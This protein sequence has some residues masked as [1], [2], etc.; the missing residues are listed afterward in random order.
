M[1]KLGTLLI[2]LLYFVT[3]AT[4]QTTSDI[5]KSSVEITWLGVD[6]SE[7]QFVGPVSGWGT[8]TTKSPSE[9]RDTYYDAW[10]NLIEKEP[11][12]FKIAEAVGRA[13]ISYNTKAVN[14]VNSKS[15]VK[16]LFVENLA[17]VDEIS[18]KEVSGMVK[19]YNITKGSGIG[20]VFICEQMNKSL[21][22]AVYWVTFIDMDN[23]KVL[24]TK[25]VNAKA[26]GF[27]F[28]N[29]WAGSIKS[30]LKTMKKEF[31]SWD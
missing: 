7:T 16:N 24:F 21:E 19:K 23:Q 8:E 12:N 22:Q 26:G 14:S 4:S 13:S 3:V 5:F 20:M 11:N 27:G 28:R 2:G 31:K 10:N 25:K 30:L 6:Y 15:S 1:K 9:M 29:Y 18:E 17:D